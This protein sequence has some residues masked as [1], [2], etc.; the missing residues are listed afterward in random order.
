MVYVQLKKCQ[1]SPY[2][3]GIQRSLSA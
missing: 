1:F 3:L 2:L